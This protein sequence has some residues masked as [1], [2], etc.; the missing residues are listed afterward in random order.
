[1]G[2]AQKVSLV[3]MSMAKMNF[4]FYG[5]LWALLVSLGTLS[6]SA[7]TGKLVIAH[8]MTDMV[9]QTDRPLNRWIDPELEDPKGSTA[10]LGG[11]YQTVPYASVFLKNAD[12]K[13]A[14][15]FEIRAARQMGIDG[16]QFYYPLGDNVSMLTNRYNEIIREFIRQSDTRHQG[17]KISLCLA[18]PHTKKPINL[19]Q[20]V[21]K[22]APPIRS[23]LDATKHSSSWL[24]HENGKLLFY[25]WVGDSLA[26]NVYGPARTLQQIRQVGQA[27]QTLSKAVGY[28]TDYIYHVRRLKIDP[29]FTQALLDTFPAVWG[30]T[31]SEENPTFWDDLARQCQLK[32]K[33]YTQTIYPDYYT[34]KVYPKGDTHH[35]ILSTK[36]ALE[37]GPEKIERHYR[38]TK[39]SQIQVDLLQKAVDRKAGIINYATWNDYPEGHHLAPEKVHR[40]GPSLLL[41]HFKHQWMTGRM[42]IENDQAIVFYKRYPYAAKPRFQTHLKIKSHDKNLAAEDRIE[43]VTFLTAPARASLCGHDLGILPAGYHLSSIPIQTGMVKVTLYREDKRV[44]DM[45][46]PVP[47]TDKPQR[48][49]RLTYSYSSDFEKEMKRLFPG[50]SSAVQE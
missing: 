8:Y 42:N 18:H 48:T 4:P 13:T 25:L 10:A 50:V 11:L 30:W 6:V 2:A 46:A 21:E 7:K 43:L 23:L 33:L 34:S 45:T 32:N 15:D 3:S 12:L 22:W 5:V 44:L 49:D 31:D 9:P 40:F 14:V 17:F 38:V 47:I 28:P 20:R 24:R 27:Y 19:Q 37:L 39:L 29:A 26:E 41:R 16:F 1:M 35:Q 36:K